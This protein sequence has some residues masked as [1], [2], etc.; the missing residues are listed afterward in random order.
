MWAPYVS[1]EIENHSID[2]RHEDILQPM[3]LAK[4]GRILAAKLAAFASTCVEHPRFGDSAVLPSDT[5]VI[6][7]STGGEVENA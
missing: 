4:I 6:P 3:S 2:C 7:T 5:A 1:G